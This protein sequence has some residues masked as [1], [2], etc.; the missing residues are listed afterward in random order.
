MTLSSSGLI[1][2]MLQSCRTWHFL[3]PRSS[4]YCRPAAS[5]RLSRTFVIMGQRQSRNNALCFVRR[6][7][8]LFRMGLHVSDLLEEQV[9]Q[10]AAF[11]PAMLCSSQGETFQKRC[12]RLSKGKTYVCSYDTGQW[13]TLRSRSRE[14]RAGAKHAS[15]PGWSSVHPRLK[16]RSCITNPTNRCDG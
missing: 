2:H 13:R 8:A 9:R 7:P 11:S 1:L 15:Q 14:T 3:S 12:W 6:A 4:C 10:L 5:G 16:S